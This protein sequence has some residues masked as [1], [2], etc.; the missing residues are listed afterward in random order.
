MRVGFSVYSFMHSIITEDLHKMNEAF[1]QVLSEQQSALMGFILKDGD[2]AINNYTHICNI[3][4]G[5]DKY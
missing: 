1:L 5:N 2:K 4:S 3:I